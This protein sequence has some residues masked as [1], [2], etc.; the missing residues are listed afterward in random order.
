MKKFLLATTA[1][2]S[3]GGIYSWANYS[4][5]Q[6]SGTTFGSVINAGVHYVQFMI[7]DLTTPAQCAAVSSVGAVKVDNSSVTQTVS[8]TVTAVVSNTVSISNSTVTVLNVNVNGQATM[9]NSSPVVIASNQSTITVSGTVTASVGDPC[10]FQV[11]TFAAISASTSNPQIIAGASGKKI[12]ICSF[13][14]IVSA[15]TTVGLIEGGTSTCST[16]SAALFGSTSSTGG[17]FLPASGGLTYGNGSGAVA[18]S[19]TVTNN[20]CLFQGGTVL[21]SGNIGYVQQ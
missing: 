3:I 13:S 12:Y 21:M 5:T 8:G 14:L 6:G 20:I 7:C 10:T 16:N 18:A 19:G 17:M 11:K 1:L 15:T 2:V 9:A 4:A